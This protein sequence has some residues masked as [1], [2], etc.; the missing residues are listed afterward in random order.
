MFGIEGDLLDLDKLAVFEL[1]GDPLSPIR[2]YSDEFLAFFPLAIREIIGHLALDVRQLLCEIA[3]GFEN[4]PAY[5]RVE[6]AAHLGDPVLKIEGRKLRAKFLDQQLPE[7]GLD[8]VMAGFTCKMAQKIYRGLSDRRS[9]IAAASELDNPGG[10]E[11]QSFP[12]WY[13]APARPGLM[14]PK[15]RS[16]PYTGVSRHGKERSV[17]R[18]AVLRS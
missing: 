1:V 4:C 9:K 14:F 16:E 2:G 13:M 10:R 8:L 18:R 17:G 11:M 5:Q 3:L 15:P 7:I 12:S 6:A